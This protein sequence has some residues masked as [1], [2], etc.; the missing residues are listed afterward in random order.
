M[1]V[2]GGR[3]YFSTSGPNL[4][5]TGSHELW[6]F[7]L[8]TGAQA[9]IGSL[10]PAITGDGISGLSGDCRL[11]GDYSVISLS[12]G[13]AQQLSLASPGTPNQLYV[14]AGTTAGAAPGFAL[15]GLLV[16]LNI[17][18]PNGYF[19]YTITFLNSPPLVNSFGFLGSGGTE[20]AHF[21]LPAGAPPALAGITVHHAF[22]VA[23]VP[24]TGVAVGVSNPV[25][26]SLVPEGSFPPALSIQRSAFI[27]DAAAPQLP[28]RQQGKTGGGGRPLAET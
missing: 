8:Y 12:A 10:G 25:S 9:L 3:G 14:V 22:A 7:D 6:T 19:N 24:G 4:V 21:A 17:D 16:P 20:V 23:D 5:P 2:R 11:D 18:G 28:S 15:S 13:G 26:V 1:A 27:L